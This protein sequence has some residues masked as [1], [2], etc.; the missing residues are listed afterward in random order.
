[1]AKEVLTEKAH[2]PA[3]GPCVVW[4]IMARLFS[5]TASRSG[6]YRCQIANGSPHDLLPILGQI[7]GSSVIQIKAERWFR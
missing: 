4:L 5:Q 6:G 1:M 7:A 3:G 2:L